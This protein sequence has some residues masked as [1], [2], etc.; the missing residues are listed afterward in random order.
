MSNATRCAACKSLRRRCPQ[1]CIL[2]PYFPPDN[3]QRF[4]DVHKVFG[5]SNVTK[6]LQDLPEHLRAAAAE[7]MSIEASTRVRDPIYGCAG[8][9]SGLQQQITQAQS[10]LA[11]TKSEIALH[12]YVQE[13]QNQVQEDYVVDANGGDDEGEEELLWLLSSSSQQNH[14]INFNNQQQQDNYSHQ[15]FHFQ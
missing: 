7:C 2:A 3:P 11:K 12:T 6:M 4:A 15:K 1:D 10:E 5:A 13:K 14:H 8:L 9:I